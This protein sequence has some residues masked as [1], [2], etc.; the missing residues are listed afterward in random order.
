MSIN[1]DQLRFIYRS[2]RIMVHGKQLVLNMIE[3]CVTALIQVLKV[4]L[5]SFLLSNI[6]SFVILALYLFILLHRSRRIFYHD[7]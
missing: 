3:W 1:V 5:S 7:L 4:L 6:F 2:L